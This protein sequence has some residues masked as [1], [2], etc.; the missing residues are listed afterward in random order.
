MTD[1][2]IYVAVITAAAGVAGATISQGTTAIRESRQA[3][4]DRQERHE[5]AT[6]EACE[7][8]LRA[9]GELRNQVANNRSFRGDRAA[10]SARLEQ[11][12]VFAADTQLHAVSVGLLAPGDL[13]E[14]AGSLA[15]AAQSLAATATHDTDLDQG[16]VSVD[17]DFTTLDTRVD[18]FRRAALDHARS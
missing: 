9:T 4:R 12:R 6:R 1:V 8:L 13:A 11:V 2:S 15:V 7:K 18:A 10:M 14:P 5:T 16:W 17:P 3:K